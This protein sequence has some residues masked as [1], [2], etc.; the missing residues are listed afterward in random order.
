[1]LHENDKRLETTMRYP[2]PSQVID[3]IHLD[4]K[5]HWDG[6]KLEHVAPFGEI[7]IT[8]FSVTYWKAGIASMHSIHVEE[9]KGQAP[10]VIEYHRPWGVRT[11]PIRF[12]PEIERPYGDDQD[13]ILNLMYQY[14]DARIQFLDNEMDFD[15]DAHVFGYLA[16]DDNNLVLAYMP[17]PFDEAGDV[18]VNR[19]AELPILNDPARMYYI[20]RQN[21]AYLKGL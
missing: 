8:D 7:S 20:T 13:D 5:Y 17:I 9:G 11:E 4:M 21:A 19:D 14:P 6:W 2:T 16:L 3:A 15:E 10:W 1:M 18:I 12:V